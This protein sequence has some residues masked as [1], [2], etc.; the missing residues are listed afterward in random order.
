MAHPV[1]QQPRYSSIDNTFNVLN[2]EQVIKMYECQEGCSS[3]GPKT[4]IALTNAR[5][6]ARRQEC[7]CCGCN[8]AHVDMAIFL[9]DIELMREARQESC[10]SCLV[11]LISI[12]TC[13]WPCL[14]CCT[15]CNR[16][17]QLEIK[18]SFGSEYLLFDTNN[19]A[20]A[21]I[22]IPAA[23]LPLK[24]NIGGYGKA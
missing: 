3:C 9:R 24:E 12:L 20:A 18:G 7:G 19:F 11:L 17:K 22:E 15:C 21:A 2:G 6:I 4:T 23:V 16:G 1:I 5:L 10:S 13:T 8:G 14:L